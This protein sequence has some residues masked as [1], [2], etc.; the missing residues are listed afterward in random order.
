M[1]I[2]QVNDKYTTIAE[3]LI[4]Y[5]PE[6]AEIRE[7][8]VTIMYLSSDSEKKKAGKLVCGQCEKVPDKYKWA[9]PCDF[10]I[11]LFEPNIER[12]TDEQIKILLYHELL[13]VGIIRDGNE[14][15]YFCRP[16]D[17]EEF[18]DIISRYGLKW[19]E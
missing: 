18:E 12:F 13:H 19:D 16:H 9:V 17:I 8:D 1:E 6:L 5:E 14:E 4:S 3:D 2:R 11:T 10:T 15:T 7:S